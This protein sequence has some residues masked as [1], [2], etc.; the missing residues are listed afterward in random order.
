[1]VTYLPLCKIHT[2]IIIQ[3]VEQFRDFKIDVL[4]DYKFAT[5]FL[6]KII[7]YKLNDL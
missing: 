2:I 4:L 7:A 5:V 3:S 1:M 6:C